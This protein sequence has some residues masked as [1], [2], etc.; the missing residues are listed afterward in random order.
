MQ[1]NINQLRQKF[2]EKRATRHYGTVAQTTPKP[3]QY[4]HGFTH[5]RSDQACYRRADEQ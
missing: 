1:L 3:L 4:R 5:D 2:T